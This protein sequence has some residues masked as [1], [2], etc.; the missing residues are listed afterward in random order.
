MEG[1]WS[2]LKIRASYSTVSWPGIF[3]DT[4]TQSGSLTH[5]ESVSIWK[6]DLTSLMLMDTRSLS[7]LASS[8]PVR[9]MAAHGP[10]APFS[11]ALFWI[12]HGQAFHLLSDL[13]LLLLHKRSEDRVCMFLCVLMGTCVCTHAPWAVA[14]AWSHG[15]ESWC[16]NIWSTLI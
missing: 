12:L 7:P 10:I 6:H 2:L 5:A 14:L 4:Q 15:D 1:E 11:P 8:L 13:L 3:W 16:G 9:P